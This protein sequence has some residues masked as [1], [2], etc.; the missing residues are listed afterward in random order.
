M[1]YV[2]H[3]DGVSCEVQSEDEDVVDVPSSDEDSDDDED[4][5]PQWEE[6]VP[7]DPADGPELIEED[8][9]DKPWAPFNS[10]ALGLLYKNSRELNAIIDDQ[11]PEG[12]PVFQRQEI[13]V[14]GE[15]FE[16]Y[17]RPIIECVRALYSNP[18][19]AQDLIFSPER[20]YAD[21]D[22]TICLYH[23]L[24]TAKWWWMT[25][26]TLER[27]KPGATIVPVIISTDK[28][29][30]TMFRNKAAYPVYMTIGN[31][32]KDI[33]CKPSRQGYILIGHLP[34]T[35]LDHTEVAAARRRTL[36]NLYEALEGH[37]CPLK[38][39]G[40][41]GIKMVSGD[42]VLRYC[43]PILAIFVGDYPEQ[44]LVAG[45]KSGECPTCVV[46]NKELGDFFEDMFEPRD[47][48][49]VLAVLAKADGNATAFTR[50]CTAAGVKPIYPFWEDLPF[51]N[52]FLSITPDILHQLYQAA[53]G[54]AEIDAHCRWPPPKHNVRLF[55]KGITTLSRISGTEHGQICRI[56]LGLIVDLH[57][58]EWHGLFDSFHDNKSIF[59]DLGIHD[60]FKIP[61]LHIISHYP[62]HVQL[63]GTFD[64]Y[65]TE[66]TERL[67]IDFTKD[68]Y[69]ATNRKDEYLQ[70]TLWSEWKEKILCHEK[71]I[72]WH[73]AGSPPPSTAKPTWRPADF[74]QHRHLQMTKFPSVYGMKLSDL[75]DNYRAEYFHDAFAHFV[76][77]F[78]NPDFSKCQVK[79]GAAD[80]FLPFQSVSVYRKIKFWNEDPLG[81]ENAGMP[82]MSYTLNP[83]TPTNMDDHTGIKGYR[84]GRVHA[85]FS[86]SEHVLNVVFTGA[87][88][89]KH[90][91]YVEWF[92]KSP[93]APDPNHKMYKISRPV[94]CTTS[95]IPVSNIRQSVHLFPQFGPVAPYKWTSE[96]VLDLC[97]KFYV[98]PWSD[99]HAY[100][101]IC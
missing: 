64:N 9:T 21:P 85:V 43:H 17:F 44:C 84:V 20:H 32:P 29:Q 67:H 92:S 45:I 55:L 53:F 100:V 66:H 70:M 47:L 27:C 96:T 52:I 72:H 56:L 36:S 61:K 93:N 8:A 97:T 19:F 82:L 99:R 10:E 15:A 65:N 77:G 24:H 11:L 89:A 95:I 14:G 90:L 41:N 3:A 34:T 73:C 26:K 22:K 4:P 54:P 51:V 91:A 5:A 37:Y 94:E 31:I 49:T 7:D 63:F 35:R 13:V 101:T 25:Q 68:A 12:R 1:D 88:P 74:V 79:A 23:D 87:K 33:R 71:F 81:R 59:I 16:V 98:S 38:D 46:P 18:E 48:D 62:L 60:N 50:A 30:T 86:F 75:T 57:L 2:P 42:G 83:A 76:I 6:P 69:R 39:A 80:Y 58:P 78:Q 40:L 28:T